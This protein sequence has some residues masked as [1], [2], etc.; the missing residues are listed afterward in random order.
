MTASAIKL[1]VGTTLQWKDSGGDYAITASSL[2]AVTG[3]I[4]AQGDLG[5]WPRAAAWRWYMEAQWVATPTADETLDLYAAFWDNDTGP[6]K[7]W[8]QVSAS[9]SALTATQRKNL[10]YIGSIVVESAA[11]GPF[12]AGGVFLAP[13]RYISPAIYNASAAKALAAVGTFPFLLRLTPIFPE[14]Q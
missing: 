9:D 12:S 13:A 5:A 4:G 2:A 11:V 6:A 1:N 3:R 10:K 8:A 14:N 7:P